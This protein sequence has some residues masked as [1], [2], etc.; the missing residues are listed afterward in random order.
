MLVIR[1]PNLAAIR[2][3]LAENAVP[4]AI[5]RGPACVGFDA[6]GQVWLQPKTPIPTRSINALSKHGASIQPES[7]I[8]LAETVGSWLELVPLVPIEVEPDDRPSRVLFDLHDAS[9][10]PALVGEFRRL[11]AG[12]IG[13]RWLNADFPGRKPGSRAILLV[14]SPPYPLDN[15]RRFARLCRTAPRVWVEVGWRHPLV[16]MIDLPKNKIVLILRSAN[17]GI[18]F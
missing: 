11:G 9:G 7:P 13:V 12:N 17:L 16:E 3:A 5:S 14:E 8:D 2:S 15:R 6:E 1:F 18:H 4:S 10:L